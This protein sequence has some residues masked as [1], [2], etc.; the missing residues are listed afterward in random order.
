MQLS[1]AASCAN[2]YSFEE[3]T[4]GLKVQQAYRITD[5]LFS[6][7][8]QLFGD[9]SPIHVDAEYAR[10]AGF[11]GRVVHGAILNGVLSHFCGMIFP[12][13]ASH[14]LSVDLRYLKPTYVGEEIELRVT[15]AQKVESL[16]AIVLKVEFF[17]ITREMTVCNG[18]VQVALRNE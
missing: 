16:K 13:R 18:R 14:L 11:D 7:F 1:D 10:Q 4:D 6:A 17:N 3:I 9:Y 5:E 2:H 15:V 8:A 12:G